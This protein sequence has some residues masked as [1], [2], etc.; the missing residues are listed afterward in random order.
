VSVRLSRRAALRGLAGLPALLAA[1]P[2]RAAAGGARF[3]FVMVPGGWD[4]TRALSPAFDVAAGPMERDATPAAAGGITY[5]HHPGRPSVDAFFAANHR[6]AV[7]IEGLLVPSVAHRTSLSLLWTGAAA[8]GQPDW[9][10][11]ISGGSGA[12]TLPHIVIDGPSFPGPYRATVARTGTGGQLQG[13]L[14]GTFVDRLEPAPPRLPD[15]VAALV[16]ARA[17]ARAAAAAAGARTPRDQALAN[18]HV[19]ALGRARAL[20]AAASTLPWDTGGSFSG[21]VRLGAALLAA[22][23]SRG[24]TLQ[25]GVEADWDSHY[26]NDE[27]QHPLTEALFAGL[28]ELGLTLD[29]TPGPSGAA[30]SDDTVVVVLS[31]MGRTPGLNGSKGKDHWPWTPALLFGAG[32]RGD[33]VV[34]SRTATLSAEPV[35]PSTGAPSA[36][37]VELGPAHLGATLLQLADIDPEALLPGVPPLT[38]ALA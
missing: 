3:V 13:L 38:C 5:V 25:F 27:R 20:Q 15:P 2:A 26:L 29:G 4:P 35:N 22:G 10:S 23:I 32:L 6:R 33:A 17:D 37:G 30:L 24:V 1:A 7:I 36:V 31:E 8:D 14:D 12:F 19:E 28:I 16:R 34:G 18:A 9:P 11:L 21:Q